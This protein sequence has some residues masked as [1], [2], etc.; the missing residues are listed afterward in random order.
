V[1]IKITNGNVKVIA[2]ASKIENIVSDDKQ[3]PTAHIK[4]PT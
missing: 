2:H 3:A 4:L 1:G